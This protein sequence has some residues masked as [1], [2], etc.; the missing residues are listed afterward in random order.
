MQNILP[1]LQI[2]LTSGNICVLGYALIK[3]LSRPHNKMDERIMDLEKQVA[4]Q[5][6]VLKEHSRKLSAQSETNEVFMNSMLSFID[7]ELAFCAHT[8]YSDTVDILK[9]KETLQKH[10][11]RSR[12]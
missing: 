10:L 2:I 5:D 6:N 11:T 9:A 12:G 1:V 7:F 4:V 3:F 8:D